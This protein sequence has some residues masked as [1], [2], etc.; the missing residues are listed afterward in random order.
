[1]EKIYDIKPLVRF[2][3]LLKVDRKEIFSVYVYAVFNGLIALSLPLGIQAIINFITA[4]QIST[5][6]VILV[7]IVLIGIAFTGVMQVMQLTITE[8]LQQKIFT[9]SAFEFAYRVPRIKLESVNQD[10]VPELVNRFFDTIT[11]QKGLSKILIDLSSA[12]LQVI[13][14]LLLLSFYH[15]FFILFSLV[16]ILVIYTIFRIISPKGLRTSLVESKHKY[17]VA[18]WLEEMGRSVE[19]F[20]L[21]GNSP[22]PLER[23]DFAV[24][25]YLKARQA[26]FKTLMAQYYNF[27][28]FKLFVAAGLLFIGGLL[29]INQQMNIGQFV[30]AEIIIILVIASVEKLIMSLENIYDVLTAIEKIS[31]VTD[32]PLERTEGSEWVRSHPN[33]LSVRLE[34]FTFLN[35]DNGQPLLTDIN[36][37]ISPGSKTVLMGSAGSGKTLLLQ[38]M[39]GLYNN[40]TGLFTYNDIAINGWNRDDL[41][42]AIGDSLANED[43]FE[44]TIEENI[45]L[46]KPGVSLEEIKG[47]CEMLGLTE[48]ISHQPHGFATELLTGGKNLPKHVKVKLLLARSLAGSPQLIL[49]D[50]TIDQLAKDDRKRL[51]DYL[52]RA[53]STVVVCSSAPD[54]V[55]FM[56]HTV[57]MHKGTIRGAGGT[58]TL[59]QD[60]FV[61]NLLQNY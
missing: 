58:A 60:P 29:V 13:F 45:S 54:V 10:H 12:T 52:L 42:S 39:A 6:W 48:F 30:A 47:L 40:F 27:I 23:T 24:A 55:N 56:D 2:F 11:V 26:H 3:N 41:R 59:L 33:G 44:G 1:M 32:L 38:V 46:R 28:G 16:L 49:L 9:R 57:V 61:L 20:K 18:H 34:S 5:S 35:P 51:L 21:A 37:A 53:P 25:K 7:I 19:T 15:P 31:N 50:D 43:L 22:L 36:L 17:E 8:N 4:G 14:G